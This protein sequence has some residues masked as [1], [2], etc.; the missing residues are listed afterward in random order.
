MSGVKQRD[1]VAGDE[2]TT[3]EAVVQRE[4]RLNLLRVSHRASEGLGVPRR[5]RVV[6]VVFHRLFGDGEAHS[7]R[8]VVV[9]SRPD[10]LS[11]VVDNTS[12]FGLDRSGAEAR[13]LQFLFERTLRGLCLVDRL[14]LVFVLLVLKTEQGV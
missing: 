12:T 6:Q 4:G 13:K 7:N 8:L 1:A 9:A 2:R 14:M 10:F 3:R 5:E 11:I